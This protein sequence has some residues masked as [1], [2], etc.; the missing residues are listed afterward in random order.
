MID[1]DDDKKLFH[2]K[3]LKWFPRKFAFGSAMARQLN[4]NDPGIWP[5]FD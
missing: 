2:I 1:K 5:Q 3:Y 4:V